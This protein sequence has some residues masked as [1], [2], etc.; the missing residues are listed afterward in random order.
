MTFLRRVILFSL[1]VVIPL[2]AIER[3]PKQ[4]G[5]E[6]GGSYIHKNA[7]SN[8]AVGGAAVMFDYSWQLSGLDGT[9]AKSFISV[10]IG[11]TYFSQNPTMGILS[12]GWT[13][14]HELLKDKLVIPYLGY[15]LLLNQLSYELDKGKRFGH[16]TRFD[17]G[18]EWLQ[19]KPFH[20]FTK[21]EWSMTRFPDRDNEES[22]WVYRLAFKVGVR[23]C[24][25]ARDKTAK[26][27][28][29]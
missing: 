10:P 17:V 1:F 19:D 2:V 4:Y 7:I 20:L 3:V 13:I 29:D 15:G 24:K 12:Y 9:R 22:D 14:R 6:F 18:A 26:P 28:E 11:Y 5:L 16:Q 8:Q 21:A 23:F 27:K 25:P